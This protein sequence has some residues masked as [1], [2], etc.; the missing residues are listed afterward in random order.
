MSIEPLILSPVMA[1]LNV[2][3]CPA[4]TSMENEIFLPATSPTNATRPRHV[5]GAGELGAVLF[6]VQRP[7][8]FAVRRI[9]RH[10]PGTR[11]AG[12]VS[13]AYPAEQNGAKTGIERIF[14]FPSSLEVTGLEGLNRKRA[15]AKGRARILAASEGLQTG[16]QLPER[17]RLSLADRLFHHARGRAKTRFLVRFDF[18]MQ[19]GLT[20]TSRRGR[21]VSRQPGYSSDG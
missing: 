10:F 14:M 1:P 13:C 7:G 16:N 4:W 18:M 8:H 20:S 21:T 5:D 15:G 12:V 19:V 6:Q 2:T 17:L 11:G 3:F 9:E